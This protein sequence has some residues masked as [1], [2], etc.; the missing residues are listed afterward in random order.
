MRAR[1]GEGI[2]DG[3]L[4]APCC[5][6]CPDGGLAGYHTADAPLG[7]GADAAAQRPHDKQDVDQNTLICWGAAL[8][9]RP[10]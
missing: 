10:M 6:A 8:R 1:R 2:F 5:G 9:G 3:A 4:D 7:A